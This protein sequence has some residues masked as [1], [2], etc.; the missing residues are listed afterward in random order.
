MIRLKDKK[1]ERRIKD[2][3]ELQIE[4]VEKGVGR[5]EEEKLV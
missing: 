2:S 1:T 4:T 5:K 3:I